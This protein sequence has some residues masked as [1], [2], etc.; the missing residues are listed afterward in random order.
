MENQENINFET[1]D[2]SEVETLQEENVSKKPENVIE[3]ATYWYNIW[4]KLP[5]II[6]IGTLIFFFIW[7]IVDPAT[8]QY[9]RGRH[10]KYGVMG[11]GSGFGCWIIWQLIGL[12]CG[13]IAYF[14]AKIST[15]P[16]ILKVEYL[17]KISEKE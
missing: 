9:G 1:D 3:N 6:F 16:T 15:A 13:G 2:C 14:F 17:K 8:I 11:I 7:G 12:V 10:T 5:K 4:L